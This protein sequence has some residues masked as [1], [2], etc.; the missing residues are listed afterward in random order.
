MKQ[1]IYF[2]DRD[3]QYYNVSYGN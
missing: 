3:Y 2:T 1:Q